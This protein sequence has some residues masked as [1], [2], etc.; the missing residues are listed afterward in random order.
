MLVTRGVGSMDKSEVTNILK[1]NKAGVLCLEDGEKPYAIPL[2]HYFNGK[3][4]YFTTSFS[5]SI[6]QPLKGGLI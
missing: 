1:N 5:H 6:L 4:L 3:S 2:E